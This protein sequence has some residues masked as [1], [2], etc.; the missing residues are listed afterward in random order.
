MPSVV[1]YREWLGQQNDDQFQGS[2][3]DRH[4]QQSG[5]NSGEQDIIQRERNEYN[6]VSALSVGNI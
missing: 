6:L 3:P 4:G 1:V 2:S 5:S